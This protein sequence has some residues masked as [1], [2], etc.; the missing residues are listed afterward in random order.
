MMAS[1]TSF[2]GLLLPICLSRLLMSQ[3]LLP[4][5]LVSLLFS[6]S[7][8]LNSFMSLLF[9]TRMLTSTTSRGDSH[10]LL[11]SFAGSFHF[12]DSVPARSI[13]SPSKPPPGLCMSTSP[14][15]T[16]LPC[17]FPPMFTMPK[18]PPLTV[19]NT[20]AETSSLPLC[21]WHLGTN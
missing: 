7:I 2:R 11:T 9:Y 5:S 19:R 16:T 14:I 8:L 20:E 3:E 21:S 13:C 10:P 12:Q 4:T 15:C 6:R 1:A 18:F 17:S